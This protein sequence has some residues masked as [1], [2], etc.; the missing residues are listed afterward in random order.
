MGTRDGKWV[1]LMVKADIKSIIW[2]SPVVFEAYGYT[3]PE[4]WEDLDALV[5]QMVADGNV[6]W[7][8]GMES[9]DA[10]G[11][12]GS[13]FIQDILLV[14]QGPEYVM[15]LITGDVPYND[16][17]GQR[18]LR[19]LWQVGEGSQVHSRWG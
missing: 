12:T 19:D 3:V 1:G 7:S 15:D 11:W 4:T 8:M 6:P 16:A 13:D 9:G 2:Y 5:E 14:K 17:G 10:T 18:S